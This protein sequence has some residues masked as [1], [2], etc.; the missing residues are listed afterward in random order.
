MQRAL[1]RILIEIRPSRAVAVFILVIHLLALAVLCISY[2]FEPLVVAIL[3]VVLMSGYHGWATFVRARGARTIRR[4]ELNGRGEWMLYDG[5]GEGRAALLQGGGFVSTW[6]VVLNF[7][8]GGWRRR[9]VILLSGNT[10]PDQ[11]RRLRV[12]LRHRL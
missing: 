11:L 4:I 10:E 9:P 12:R 6:L 3:P 2:P 5:N 8:L 7:S 1:E